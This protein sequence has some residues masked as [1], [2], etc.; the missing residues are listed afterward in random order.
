MKLY[1]LILL[2]VV[3]IAFTG[4]E[5]YLEEEP[6]GEITSIYAETPD[7]ITSLV[8]SLYSYNRDLAVNMLYTGAAG[9]D[10]WTMAVN[11]AT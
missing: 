3:L 8:N 11:Q 6:K 1:K 5:D 10:I 9:T 2:I 4:C 7:G